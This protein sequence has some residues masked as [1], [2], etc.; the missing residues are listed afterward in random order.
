MSGLPGRKA[1]RTSCSSGRAGRGSRRTTGRCLP[2]R[3]SRSGRAGFSR[4]LTTGLRGGA[5]FFRVTLTRRCAASSKSCY[6]CSYG[7]MSRA[8]SRLRRC[9]P[10]GRRRGW[11]RCRF[12]RT[13]CSSGGLSA[14][15]TFLTFSRCRTCFHA[16]SRATNYFGGRVYTLRTTCCARG[17]RRFRIRRQ[18]VCRRSSQDGS[19][20]HV[21]HFTATAFFFRSRGSGATRRSFRF[22]FG[23]PTGCCGLCRTVA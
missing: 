14:A 5:T 15:F 16:C 22:F 9:A 7:G 23:M 20:G 3:S 12:R 2:M 13:Y 4:R 17:F 18:K 8:T 6:G 21:A 19:S 10:F 1:A 11:R